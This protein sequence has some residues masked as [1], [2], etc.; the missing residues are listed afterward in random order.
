[1]VMTQVPC[2]IIFHSV[3][4]VR[5]AAP[6]SRGLET[7]AQRGRVMPPGSAVGQPSH[8]DPSPSVPGTVAL[9]PA[10]VS[11]SADGGL[12]Y[13]SPTSTPPL[14]L[15]QSLCVVRHNPEVV[16]LLQVTSWLGVPVSRGDAEGWLLTL[17]SPVSASSMLGSR[18]CTHTQGQQGLLS[19]EPQVHSVRQKRTPSYLTAPCVSVGDTRAARTVC[20]SPRKVQCVFL[21]HSHNQTC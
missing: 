10:S 4:W 15:L 13:G 17:D 5:A 8:C 12:T 21:A 7:E 16:S 2:P 1:M 9:S 19:Q 18:V 6:I 20:V 11:L 14:L 3:L